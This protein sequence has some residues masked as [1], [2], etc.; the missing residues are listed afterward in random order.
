MASAPSG[1]SAVAASGSQIN[2]SWSNNGP[3]TALYLWWKIDGGS[4]ASISLSAS[5]TSY[6]KIDLT[7]GKKYYFYV[8]AEWNAGLDG[9][10]SSIVNA[11]TTL[12]NPTGAAATPGEDE[13]ALTWSYSGTGAESMNVYRGSTLIATLAGSARSYTAI[14]L[15]EGVS[16]TFTI[17]AYTSAYGLTT[18]TSVT[19]TTLNM[20]ELIG[21]A[22]LTVLGTTSI[23]I[24]RL[25]E[26]G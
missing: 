1:V 12:T 20:P 21:G 15:S 7:D 19:T 8:A 3:Y 18:G 4:Y 25:D 22:T 23:K 10:S 5:A 6:N 2:V 14:G 11:T 16:Y 24:D 13:V 17:K 26:R 9:G